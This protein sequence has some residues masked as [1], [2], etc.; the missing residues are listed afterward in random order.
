MGLS[1]EKSIKTIEQAGFSHIKV[2]L[3]AH[4]QRGRVIDSSTPCDDCNSTG[5]IKVLNSLGVAGEAQECTNCHGEGHTGGQAYSTGSETQCQD[6]INSRLSR[7]CRKSIVFMRFYNDGSVDSELTFTLPTRDARY[8]LEVI[9]AFNKLDELLGG[10]MNVTG[11]GMHMS[12]LPSSSYP[13]RTTLPYENITNFKEQVGKLLPALYIAATSGPF[14]RGLR[15]RQ[16]EITES[17]YGCISTHNDTC[18]EYRIFETCY[19]RP[20]AIFEYLGTIA[21]TLEYYIDPTKEVSSLGAQFPIY[22]GQGLKG[23]T[24]TAEQIDILKKQFKH[25][26][27][28]G[29]TVKQFMADRGITLTKA[30]ITK[31]Q[32]AKIR[33]L[34]LAYKED[35]RAYETIRQKPLTEYQLDAIEYHK[36]ENPNQPE[37]FY[38]ERV[39]GFSLP[40]VDEATYIKNNTRPALR[41]TVMLSV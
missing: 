25:V 41:P 33:K 2:E 32:L 35:V 17:K 19:Q 18:L 34:K 39:T 24:G 6:F 23:Y 22:D 3:E 7:E 8:V 14:T 20:E 5:Y 31:E 12:V 10:R 21:K 37:E 38:W 30:P 26:K 13:C 36:R 40:K 29:I 15:Y 11:A 9:A 16:A 4:L 27:P 28:E 1:L